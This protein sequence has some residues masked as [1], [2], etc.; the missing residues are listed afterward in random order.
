M[1]TI[2][3]VGTNNRYVENQKPVLKIYLKLNHNIMDFAVL[4]SPVASSSFQI[5]F[6]SFSSAATPFICMYVIDMSFCVFTKVNFSEFFYF[7]SH[8]LF[9]HY[10]Q[11]TSMQFAIH[12]VFLVFFSTNFYQ[13]F[14]FQSQRLPA[15]LTYSGFLWRLALDERSVGS[16]SCYGS[17][18]SEN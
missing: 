3:S 5:L 16:T 18:Q 9:V 13:A 7:G 2:V 10:Q 1:I 12:F 14:L 4:H 11:S 15:T 17:C 6:W 8:I